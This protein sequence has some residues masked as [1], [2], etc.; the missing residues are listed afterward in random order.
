MGGGKWG[1]YLIIITFITYYYLYYRDE[2]S[3]IEL[4]FQNYFKFGRHK[5]YYT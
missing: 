3:L 1:H 4:Q 2:K 5:I